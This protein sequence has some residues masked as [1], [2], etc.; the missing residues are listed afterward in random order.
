MSIMIFQKLCN[1]LEALEEMNFDETLMQL[2]ISIT[3]MPFD[4]SRSKNVI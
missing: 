2:L 4:T 3:L 1:I